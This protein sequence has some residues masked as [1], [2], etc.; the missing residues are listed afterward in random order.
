MGQLIPYLIEL[1]L[2]GEIE[3]KQDHHNSHEDE[4]I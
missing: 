2:K 1:Y 3:S 4:I